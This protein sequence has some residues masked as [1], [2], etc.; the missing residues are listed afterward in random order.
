MWDTHFD[1]PGPAFNL[2]VG[3]SGGLDSAGVVLFWH[4]KLSYAE[5]LVL[6]ANCH[7]EFACKML[8]V[9]LG[10][11]CI[12]PSNNSSDSKHVHFTGGKGKATEEEGEDSGKSKGHTEP[13][14]KLANLDY[15]WTCMCPWL[16]CGLVL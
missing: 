11:C 14:A 15:L 13:P 8:T 5:G 4:S 7:E 6:A 10:C 2:L 12:V 1:T 9:A 3:G 16:P